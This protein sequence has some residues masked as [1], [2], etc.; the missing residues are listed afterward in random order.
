MDHPSDSN[1]ESCDHQSE[2]QTLQLVQNIVQSWTAQKSD[3]ELLQC[4]A[5]QEL[6]AYEVLYDRYSNRL[7]Q[8]IFRIVQDT[9]TADEVLQETF[10]QVWQSAPDYQGLGSPRAWVYQIARHRSLDQLRLYKTRPQKATMDVETAQRLEHRHECSAEEQAESDLE[11]EQV[12]RA[13]ESLPV[14]QRECLELAYFEG[15]SQRQI[16]DALHTPTGT[17]KSRIRLGLSKLEYS[18]RCE[19]YRAG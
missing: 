2:Q 15:L 12:L 17:I 7:Y 3:L 8:M 14:E 18:L 16:A 10:W 13:L 11:R 9:F 6:D 1:H 4:V 5:R 19:G